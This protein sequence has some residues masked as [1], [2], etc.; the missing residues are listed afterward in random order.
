MAEI[1]N[2]RQLSPLL[3]ESVVDLATHR[4]RRQR[5][6][7]IAHRC[8]RGCILIA[9]GAFV[10]GRNSGDGDD[11]ARAAAAVLAMPDTRTTTLAR[12]R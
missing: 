8:G 2:T 12:N 7:R 1:G 3:P 9:V 5:M 6:V 11:Y 10:V 4:Q